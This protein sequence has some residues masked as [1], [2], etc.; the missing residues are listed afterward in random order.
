M[1]VTRGLRRGRHGEVLIS[2]VKFQLCM[3]NNSRDPYSTVPK[4]TILCSTFK[5]F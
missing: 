5:H 1:V 2:G 3:M 4:L